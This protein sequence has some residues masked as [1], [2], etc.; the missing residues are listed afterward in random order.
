[1]AHGDSILAPAGETVENWHLQGKHKQVSADWVTLGGH[2]PTTG[3]HS[4]V[5]EGS[6]GVSS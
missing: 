6:A 3:T 2:G 4:D 5:K 1:M